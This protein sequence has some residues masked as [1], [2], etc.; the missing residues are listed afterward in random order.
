MSNDYENCVLSSIPNPCFLKQFLLE[1]AR[2]FLG[3][4][5]P[6]TFRK[7]FRDSNSI[8]RDL[9]EDHFGKTNP[10]SPGGQQRR[11]TAMFWLPVS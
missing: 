2:A 3:V 6:G 10:G 7:V 5:G 9:R 1:H 8:S 4:I 11:S